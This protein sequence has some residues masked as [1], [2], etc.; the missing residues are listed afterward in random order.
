M[1]FIEWYKEMDIAHDINE[2]FCLYRTVQERSSN[3]GYDVKDSGKTFT[4]AS[5]FA[6][7]HRFSK[8]TA[9]Q[10]CDYLDSLYD[11]GVEGEHARFMDSDRD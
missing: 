10:F 5:T 1:S 6:E 9:Q 3:Y 7:P 8:K 4:V 2:V 11:T